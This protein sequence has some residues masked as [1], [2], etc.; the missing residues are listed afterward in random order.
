MKRFLA[1]TQLDDIVILLIIIAILQTPGWLIKDS[2][3][4]FFSFYFNL[5]PENPVH[6]VILIVIFILLV[7]A[8]LRF[9]KHKMGR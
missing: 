3:L 6:R 2:L 5:D 8:I 4:D 7:W 9:T 1:K